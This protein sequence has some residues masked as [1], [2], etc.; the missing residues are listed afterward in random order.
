MPVLHEHPSKLP[1]TPHAYARP[2]AKQI[3]L[4]PEFVEDSPSVPAS[5]YR[6]VHERQEGK[7]V[8]SIYAVTHAAAQCGTTKC[9]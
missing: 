6:R 5:F 3:Q 1:R 7:V 4:E 8:I 2:L 9:P